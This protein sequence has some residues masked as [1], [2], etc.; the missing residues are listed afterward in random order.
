MNKMEIHGLNLEIT[1]AI[2]QY[3]NKKLGRATKHTSEFI[4]NMR[5]N[6]SYENRTSTNLVE[7]IIFL[8]GGKTLRNQTRSEDMYASVDISCASV[9]RQ[10]RKLKEKNLD[11]KRYRSLEEKLTALPELGSAIAV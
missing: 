10:L 4:S 9:E 11:L 6:L 8:H 2:E 7:V 1:R 3:V 5:V